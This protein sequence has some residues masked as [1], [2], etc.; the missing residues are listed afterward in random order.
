MTL[1]FLLR[2]Y[3]ETTVCDCCAAWKLYAL[4]NAKKNSC[5]TNKWLHSRT[6]K[7]YILYVT[8]TMSIV[9]VVLQA[10]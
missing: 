1:V 10:L 3:V 6:A 7:N 4:S 5:N 2:S 8:D 9:P